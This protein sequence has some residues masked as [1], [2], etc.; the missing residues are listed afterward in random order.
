MSTGKP[1][2]A[3]GH[4][5]AN[6]V[7]EVKAQTNIVITGLRRSGEASFYF[8]NQSNN[9]PAGA[10][11]VLS[12]SR[13][14]AGRLSLRAAEMCLTRLKRGNTQAGPNSERLQQVGRV[15]FYA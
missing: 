10:K 4:S 3:L 5:T 12:R 6:C 11:L 9:N 7:N 14:A 15:M 13:G 2:S 8:L 1:V